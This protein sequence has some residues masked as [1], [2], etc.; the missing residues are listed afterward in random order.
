[1]ITYLEV[2]ESMEHSPISN[3][4]NWCE[5]TPREKAALQGNWN[6]EEDKMAQYF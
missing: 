3:S 6:E 5:R 4:E 1:M 2:E